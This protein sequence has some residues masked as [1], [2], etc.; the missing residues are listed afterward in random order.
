MPRK[1]VTG[2]LLSVSAFFIALVLLPFIWWGSTWRGPWSGKA[3]GG[4]AP[5]SAS[6]NPRSKE[7][8]RADAS[9]ELT[10][11]KEGEEWSHQDLIEWLGAQGVTFTAVPAQ[12][13]SP[14]GCKSRRRHFVSLPV[15]ESG[16]KTWLG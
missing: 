2:A 9:K 14:C 8:G 3:G 13:G 16:E 7:K 15:F 4:G 10:E 1:T 12:R 5:D 11:S 6:Q